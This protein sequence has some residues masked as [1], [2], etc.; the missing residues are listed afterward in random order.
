MLATRSATA[1]APL[2]YRSPHSPANLTPAD[3]I[4]LNFQP[5]PLFK[6]T[7]IPRPKAWQSRSFQPD[8]WQPRE[9]IGLRLG[10]QEQTGL[11]LYCL[12]LDSH[13]E[14]Q[15]AERFLRRIFRRLPAALRAH[16]FTAISTGGAGRYIMFLCR[17]ELA[18]GLVFD[19]KIRAGEFLGAGRHVVCPTPDRWLQNK[20]TGLSILD[21]QDLDLLLGACGYRPSHTSKSGETQPIE[22]NDRL[23][24]YW[25][26]HIDHLMG[27]DGYPKW[28]KPRSQTYR[29]ITGSYRSGDPSQ[30]RY[31]VVRGLMMH[32]YDDPQIVALTLHFCAWNRTGRALYT[33]ILRCIAKEKERQPNRWIYTG[34][35]SGRQTT[36]Q[37]IERS[38]PRP[39]GRP[40]AYTPETYLDAL[41]D[42]LDAGDHVFKTRK[43]RAQALSC[44][45]STVDRVERRLIAKG[46]IER[47]TSKDRSRSWVR[48]L[49][50][51]KTPAQSEPKP[52]NLVLSGDP[53]QTQVYSTPMPQT[54][55]GNPTAIEGTRL[56]GNPPATLAQPGEHTPACL[57]PSES[58]SGSGGA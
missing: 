5:I 35:A 34:A 36:A 33:D 18:N 41:C 58:A 28:L 9:G 54:E 57:I 49:G 31:N 17:V 19:R 53:E 32:G 48:V 15:N 20:L 52:A 42:L 39:A 43:E 12:D 21:D 29:T 11:Y 1:S 13:T 4:A 26:Q 7:K 8:D 2:P 24:A 45:V 40:T 30:D 14:H 46:K 25:T 22:I 38:T 6:G 23:I 16:L 50:A 47:G 55:H 37:P 51:I 44:S 10:Y 3:L 56:V 27:K